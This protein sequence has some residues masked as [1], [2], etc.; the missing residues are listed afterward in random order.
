MTQEAGL[1]LG[2]GGLDGRDGGEAEGLVV[3]G[4]DD[5]IRVHNVRLAAGGGPEG[6]SELPAMKRH[7]GGSDVL[8]IEQVDCAAV[9][10]V[11]P[12]HDSRTERSAKDVR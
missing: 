9:G 10:R 6:T 3:E 2:D 12:R 8:A 1:P 4:V 11:G 5:N 7:V